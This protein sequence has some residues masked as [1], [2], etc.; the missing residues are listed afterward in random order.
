MGHG[1]EYQSWHRAPASTPA[2]GGQTNVAQS[3]HGGKYQSW[4]RAPASTPA[5]GGQTNV[6]QSWQGGQY[7]SWHRAPESR[8]GIG[9][10]FS[11]HV[12][13]SAPWQGEAPLSRTQEKKEPGKNDVRSV[14]GYLM[15]C[16]NDVA[17]QTPLFI[18]IGT[19][20]RR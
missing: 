1:G 12:R 17:V 13:H 18:F 5:W 4:H 19:V 16:F 14:I 15:F 7:Q 11:G 8:L 6:A 2:W 10:P 9:K 3:W 20:L